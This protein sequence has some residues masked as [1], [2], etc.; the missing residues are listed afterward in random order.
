LLVV[1]LL[2]APGIYVTYRWVT[3]RRSR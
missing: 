2:I 3:T 1:L